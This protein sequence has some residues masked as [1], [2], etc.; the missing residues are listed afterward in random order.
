MRRVF[1]L[2]T[3][4]RLTVYE[5]LRDYL[6]LAAAVE[7]EV[8]R[9][10]EARRKT[11][12]AM[13]AV[14]AHLGRAEGEGIKV[15][16]YNQARR[17][18]GLDVSEKQIRSA[19]GRWREANRVLA[20]GKARESPAQRSFRRHS[21]GKQPTKDTPFSALCEWLHDE[22][23]VAGAPPASKGATDY[24]KYRKV[25][26]ATSSLKDLPRLPT[27]SYIVTTTGLLWEDCVACALG[28]ADADELREQ[29]AT[30]RRQ[31][32]G[33]LGLISG[34]DIARVFGLRQL[35]KADTQKP[36]FP[37]IVAVVGGFNAWVGDDVRAYHQGR[38]FPHR[39]PGSYQDK[40]V[41]AVEAA[42]LLGYHVDTLR[43]RISQESPLIPMP[44][45]RVGN[46]YYWRRE[47]VTN[48]KKPPSRRGKA[49]K[50][51]PKKRSGK[52]R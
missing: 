3:R 16:E 9:E 37:V 17:E 29:R 34:A 51:T 2:S 49:A 28:E 1:A 41:D 47:T 32:E 40:L 12:E 38:D 19:W 39:D 24:G 46:A 27:A 45:G 42:Q 26:N 23:G 11:L 52:G 31:D 8:E 10:I 15:R 5:E 35:N 22:H 14:A 13:R 36:G 4:E 43:T 44:E 18:L 30:E 48:W 50:K 20:G 33:P 21:S 6:G 25:R 7:T